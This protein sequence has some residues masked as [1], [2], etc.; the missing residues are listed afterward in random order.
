[1]GVERPIVSLEM[2]LA[3]KASRAKSAYECL[4]RIFCKRLLTTA[5]IDWLEGC[6]RGIGSGASVVMP[7]GRCP[8]IL[9]SAGALMRFGGL[10]WWGIGSDVRLMLT[11]GICISFVCAVLCCNL[12][13]CP[14]GYNSLLRGRLHLGRH[15]FGYETANPCFGQTG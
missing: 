15:V 1:M 9:W 2:F 8:L 7:V 4:G 10:W 5:A 13:S 14:L 6:D 12:L 11:G 3:A